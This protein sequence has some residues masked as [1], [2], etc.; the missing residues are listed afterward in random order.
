MP[1]RSTPI[2][3]RDQRRLLGNRVVD[4]PP[5]A[6]ASTCRTVTLWILT[7]AA[8]A[9]AIG[10]AT[11][12][13]VLYLGLDARVRTLNSTTVYVTQNV[14]SHVDGLVVT[15]DPGDGDALIITQS[16][17]SGRS[18]GGALNT[19]L[20]FASDGNV[21]AR[22]RAVGSSASDARLALE[23]SRVDVSALSVGATTIT[24]GG[25]SYSLS[26]L[27]ATAAEALARPLSTAAGLTANTAVIDG[28]VT[29]ATV[30]ATLVD[31]TTVSGTNAR[32]TSTLTAGS[33]T[34]AGS[35]TANA[36]S[37]AGTLTAGTALLHGASVSGGVTAT[38][39]SIGGALTAG[40]TSVA[41]L[42]TSGSATAASGSVTGTLT[43]GSLTT[44][45]LTAGAA[46]VPR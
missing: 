7:I 8:L 32:F 35:I 27:S 10:A 44:G 23:A 16:P 41:S 36:A 6:E 22:V 39:G 15:A 33:V 37:V 3:D 30:D 46:R 40:A 20:A 34:T 17:P 18:A 4:D 12:F 38:S 21:Y 43:S 5:Q 13:V 11:A 1:A 26:A 29:A 2:S 31:A 42:S 25:T 45:A 24:V 9:I 19:S 14:T 28:A